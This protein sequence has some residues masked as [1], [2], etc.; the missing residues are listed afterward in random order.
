[1]SRSEEEEGASDLT[2]LAAHVGNAMI[3]LVVFMLR[4]CGP[5]SRKLF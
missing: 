3:H 4:A 5:N 1:M 2:L